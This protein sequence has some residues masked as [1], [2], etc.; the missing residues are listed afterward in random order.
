MNVDPAH[1]VTSAGCQVIIEGALIRGER[2]ANSRIY[3]TFQSDQT[4]SFPGPSPWLVAG[5]EVEFQTV[6][7]PE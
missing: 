3:G 1:L 7:K 4:T 2:T 6:V 5:N